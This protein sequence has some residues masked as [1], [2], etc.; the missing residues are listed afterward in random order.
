MLTWGS[1]RLAEGKTATGF[2]GNLWPV[3]IRFSSIFPDLVGITVARS[4][5]LP[6]GC[7]SV[8]GRVVWLLV[9]FDCVVA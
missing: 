6:L 8:V 3:P 2:W 7:E 5:A 9:Q 4:G 1:T